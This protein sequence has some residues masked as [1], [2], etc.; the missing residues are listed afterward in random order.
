MKSLKIFAI[1]IPLILNVTGYENC[2]R[3]QRLTEV[4]IFSGTPKEEYEQ[5]WLVAL[6]NRIRDNFICAGSLIS[7][8]HVLTGKWEKSVTGHLAD[9]Q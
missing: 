9:C 5:P 4:R 6:H 8:K 7:N 3:E 1:L 2:G